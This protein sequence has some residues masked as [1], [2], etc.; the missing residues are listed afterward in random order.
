MK[1]KF[2][3]DLKKDEALIELESR[4]PESANDPQILADAQEKITRLRS[5]MK[6][7]KFDGVLIT[8]RD[9]FAWLTVGGDNHVVN[10]TEFGAG[11]LLITSDQQYLIAYRMDGERLNNEQISSQGYQLVT[12]PWYEGDPRQKALTLGA[13]RLA[14]D[15]SFPGAIDRSI[16]IDQFHEPLTTLEM[17]RC[18]WLGRQTG[19]IL[20]AVADWIRPGM[21]E[22]GIAWYTR[23]A[24]LSR[25]IE[26][27]VLLVG[28]DE[29]I[30]R[31]NHTIPTDKKIKNF[32]FMDPAARKWGLHANVNRCVCFGKPPEWLSKAHQA[33]ATLEGRL[34][35][36]LKEGLPFSKILD[37]QKKLYREL[38]YD[39][40][41]ENHF[42]GG[43]TGYRLGD[44][45]RWQTKTKVQTG[46]AF[47]WFITVKN[48]QVEEL[49][50]LT[51]EGLE[52]ASLGKDWPSLSIPIKDGEVIVPN[53]WVR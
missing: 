45:Y 19:L 49:S 34:L 8:R 43:P 15:T 7:K 53:L 23:A 46:Q 50:L 36:I 1:Y 28:S 11:H 30:E 26:L 41:W 12:I 13:K 35:G 25:G 14:A 31:F 9:N 20:E 17:D 33:A 39:S 18:R 16:E 48:V 29:R 5:W 24:F 2:D 51:N 27:D 6:E 3:L 47:D 52:V 22:Q 10:N 38:G 40:E 32:I 37:Y 42:Q 21:S 4:L 44:A